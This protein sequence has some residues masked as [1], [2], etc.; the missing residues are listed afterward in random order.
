MIGVDT[1]PYS[2]C[3]DTESASEG[4]E[5]F[6]SFLSTPTV[7]IANGSAVDDDVPQSST[8]EEASKSSVRWSSSGITSEAV[9]EE[10]APAESAAATAT[11]NPGDLEAGTQTPS[12]KPDPFLIK[13][14]QDA[15]TDGD[16]HL[17]RKELK[18]S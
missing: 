8:E 17:S 4:F 18:V 12:T 16:G 1:P 7:T 5:D 13:A 10:K 3:S 9:G 15:D 14:F 2:S 11:G 6:L